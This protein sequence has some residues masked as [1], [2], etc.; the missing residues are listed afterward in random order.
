LPYLLS[1]INPNA[2]I[3]AGIELGDAEK[4]ELLVI[5]LEKGTYPWA[6]PLMLGYD[7]TKVQ[8]KPLKWTTVDGKE[9]VDQCLFICKWGGVLTDAGIKQARAMGN[10]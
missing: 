2:T 1:N 8:L 5:V 10:L 3:G 7:G 4:L 6:L 9:Y